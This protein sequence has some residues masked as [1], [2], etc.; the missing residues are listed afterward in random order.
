MEKKS[1]KEFILFFGIILLF[2]VAIWYVTR[3][4]PK[5]NRTNNASTNEKEIINVD[6]ETAENVSGDLFGEYYASAEEMLSQMTLEEKVGQM[7]LARYPGTGANDE[8]ANYNPGGYVLFGADFRD[9]SKESALQKININQQN[10]KI[11]MFMAVDEEGGTV[12]RV[13][14]YE[15]FREERFKSPRELFDSDSLA[16]II[17]DSTEKSLLLH[18]VGINM[19]L[20]PVA[21]VTQNEDS[22][23]YS[24]SLGQNAEVTS[25]YISTLINQM[26]LDN[27]ISCLKHFPGYGENEDTHTGIAIDNKSID[28]FRNNDFLPFK[29]GINVGAPCIL[30]SHNIVTSMDEAN[31]ASLSENVHNLLRDELGFSGLIITDDLAMDAVEEYVNDGTAA[32]KAV[33]AGNDLI[34]SSD[35][36]NQKQEV[37]DAI[38]SGEISEETINIAVRRILSCKMKYGIIK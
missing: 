33:K 32:V 38:S 13:S 19:N 35:F 25:V 37:L 22:F 16:R 30:V 18:S 5:I 27:M 20:A 28:E 12:A 17:D 15:A 21:D 14:A 31:P 26:N 1:L 2:G 4:N 6:V 24:R 8:I 29:A 11:P 36:Q 10:S 3:D 7:F 34:I 23:M 9:E